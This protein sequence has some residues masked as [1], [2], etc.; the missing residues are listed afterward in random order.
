[1]S[2]GKFPRGMVKFQAHGWEDRQAVGKEGEG[3]SFCCEV[4]GI[5]SNYKHK[6]A[7]EISIFISFY[8]D[9]KKMRLHLSNLSEVTELTSGWAGVQL[10]THLSVD[11]CSAG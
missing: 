8:S 11:L 6:S 9:E 2:H 4:E 7:Q 5:K 3:T 10:L 1:M